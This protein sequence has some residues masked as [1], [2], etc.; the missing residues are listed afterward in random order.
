MLCVCGWGWGG[1]GG[2]GGVGNNN[3]VDLQTL[4]LC[5]SLMH[6]SSFPVSTS[7][8][9]ISFSSVPENKPMKTH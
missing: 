2:G 3:V 5:A 7:V 6:F 8:T 1:G 9:K 4:Y